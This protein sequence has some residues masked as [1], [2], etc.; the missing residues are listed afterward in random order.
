[1]QHKSL[2]LAG[3][4]A[5]GMS[6]FMVPGQSQAGFALF[7]VA[8]GSPAGIQATVDA[9][10]AA[11]GT[12]NPN[13]PGSVGSGRREINWDGVPAGSSDPNGFAGNFFNANVAGR[14]RGV[15]FST[16]GSGFLVSAG[17]GIATPPVFGFPLDF[18][19][20]SPQKLFSP[21]GSVITDILFFVPGSSTA[22]TVSGF[23]AVFNDVEV[24]GSTRLEAFDEL[25]QSLFGRN[26]LSGNS[27]SLSFLGILANAGEQIARIR[28]TT[29]NAALLTNG[30]FGPGSDGVVMDDFI[31]AEP[32]AGAAAVVP[33]P[34]S[35][36]LLGSGLLSLLG[37]G[38][39]RRLA[40]GGDS[41]S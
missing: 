15:E 26:V 34:A 30:S 33:V 35:V 11:L 38:W 20:F 16:P 18:V 4:L 27:G 1:M 2:V 37:L 3:A 28:L 14:A 5:L 31:Y 9:Y 25:G 23:G 19:P 21:V 6:T 29:G 22:A 32:L 12:L 17:V 39:K 10:R 41:G 7:E 40:A 36:L 13:N 24:A 8:A